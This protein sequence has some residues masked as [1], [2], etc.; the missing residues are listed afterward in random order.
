MKPGKII[1]LNGTSSAG[2][3]TLAHALQ[4]ELD[5]PWL[6]VSLDQYRDG[7]PAKYR[8]LNAPRGSKGEAGLN[9]VPVTDNGPPHTAV[10]FGE[11]GK[12]VLQGMRRAIRALV[13]AGTNVIIDDIILEAGFLQD[14]LEVLRGVDVLFVGVTCSMDVINRREALRPGRFPGTALGHLEV[15]HA[16]GDYDVT[17]DTGSQSPR[18]CARKVIEFLESGTPGAFERIRQH[19]AGEA[20][21]R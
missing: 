3:T 4:E 2:K 13:D 14:Y 5:A 16:H 17:V 8:G 9:V 21:P 19:Q 11:A 15:C 20:I 7:L 1:F 10:V 18:A 12:T 6:H